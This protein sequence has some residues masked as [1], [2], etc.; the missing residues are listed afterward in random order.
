MDTLIGIISRDYPGNP[1]ASIIKVIFAGKLYDRDTTIEAVL[2]NRD[3]SEALTLHF[4]AHGFTP[5]KSARPPPDDLRTQS[6]P[7]GRGP[8]AAAAAAA[9]A[10][11][12]RAGSA[13]ESSTAT[14]AAASPPAR[15]QGI[16]GESKES[17]DDGVSAA[18]ATAAA[19][20]AAAATAAACSSDAT[21]PDPT[22][23][24][25]VGGRPPLAPGGR[26]LPGG[27]AGGRRPPSSWDPFS[28][29]PQFSPAVAPYQMQPAYQM[30]QLQQRQQQQQMQ[31]QMQMQ[32][33]V[34][35]K[36]EE[37]EE[38]KK[39]GREDGDNGTKRTL[40]LVVVHVTRRCGGSNSC[41]VVCCCGK[42]LLC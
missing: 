5:Q 23:P 38:R 15:A 7:A 8:A 36:K 42:P 39:R 28:A 12:A 41:M 33:Y 31:V 10:G 17:R 6:A 35:S 40:V 16:L 14:G 1:K 29:S 3:L 26:P 37:E 9:A 18:A 4:I 32:Q 30:Q 20:T 25:R 21:H 13:P 19:A 22:T 2:K 27:L 34:I 24:V 11:G